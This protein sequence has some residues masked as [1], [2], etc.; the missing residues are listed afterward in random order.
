MGNRRRGSGG[1]ESVA[2]SSRQSQN[3]G[4]G[5]RW[6]RTSFSQK[7]ICDTTFLSDLFHEKERQMAGPAMSFLA[8]HREQPFLVSVVSFGEIAVMYENPEEVRRLFS[9]YRVLRLTPEI[10]ITAAAI[11]RELIA[12]GRRLGENDNWIAGFCRYYGQPVISRD[13]AFDR[14]RGLRRVS[15]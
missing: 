14:V 15:Y 12:L 10:A 4:R 1:N 9:H 13:A 8:G 7:V 11:D 5:A 3:P 2:D 6:S